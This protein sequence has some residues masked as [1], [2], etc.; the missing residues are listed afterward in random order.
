MAKVGDII[1]LACPMGNAKIKQGE[2]IMAAQDKDVADF[3]STLL[4]SGTVTH[5]MHLST[6]SFAVHMA[7]G[8]YYTEIIELVDNFAEA[9]SGAYQKIKTFPE[10]FHNAKDP[11][12]YLE[13]ICDY[14]KKNRKAMPDD[15]QLQNIIDEIAALIDSTLYKLTLK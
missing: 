15:S 6:D 13:S 1:R 10:N 4:H 5:F 12:R 7:L 9:Y 11:V 14:V 2:F 3:I 8:G